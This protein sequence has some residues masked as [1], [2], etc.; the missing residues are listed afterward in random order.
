MTIL[1]L[2]ILFLGYCIIDIAP[3]LTQRL[4]VVSISGSQSAFIAVSDS[5]FIEHMTY[6]MIG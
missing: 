4:A 2:A 5:C 3:L 1:L 6:G